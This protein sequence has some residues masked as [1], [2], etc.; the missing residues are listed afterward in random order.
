M[1]TMDRAPDTVTAEL[2]LAEA[3][4]VRRLAGALVADPS[5]A[6]DVAQE[7]LRRG[8]EHPPTSRAGLRGWLATVARNVVRSRFRADRRRAGRELAV[9]RPEGE[10][11]VD[12]VVAR[13]E[14]HRRVVEAVLALEEPYRS[15]ILHRYFDDLGPTAIAARTGTPVDT[16]RTHLHRALGRLRGRL[17]AS[18]GGD[19]AATRRALLALMGPAAGASAPADAS[20]D[21]RADASAGTPRGRASAP[22]STSRLVPWLAA[23]TVV[24]GGVTLLLRSQRDVP[25]AG[26][27]AS[28]TAAA[29]PADA[30]DTPAPAL[31]REAPPRL[32]A[33]GNAHRGSAGR[34]PSRTARLSGIVLDEAG[35]PASGVL[36]VGRPWRSTREE[37]QELHPLRAQRL[38][39][40][41]PP[42]PPPPPRFRTRSDATGAFSL[43]VEDTEAT[44]YLQVAAEPAAPAVG[45]TRFY[46]WAQA[47]EET[48]TLRVAAGA[49]LR[50]RIV[51]A[52]GHGLAATVS[53]ERREPAAAEPWR[54][55]GAAVAD[56]DGR[57]TLDAAPLGTLS[58]DVRAGD[59]LGVNGHL[60]E[61]RAGEE[62]LVRVGVAGGAAVEG[63]VTDG[64]GAPVRGADVLVYTKVDGTRNEWRNVAARTRADGTYRVEGLAACLLSTLLVDA[65][66]FAPISILRNTPLAAGTTERWD[67]R[68][69]RGATLRGRVLGEDG[70]VPEG[71]VVALRHPDLEPA[72]PTR[73]ARIDAEGRFSFEAV[74]L[75][76]AEWKVNAPG[77]DDPA[78]EAV[79]V[80]ADGRPSQPWRSLRLGTEGESQTLELRLRRGA[81]VAGTVV[82]GDGRPVEGARIEVVLP[83]TPGAEAGSGARPATSGPDGRFTLD[84]LPPGSGASLRALLP[85]ARTRTD[86]P[87][88]GGPGPHELVL[89]LVRTGS[90]HGRV[91]DER[92]E[93]LRRVHVGLDGGSGVYAD[94]AGRFRLS[95]VPIGP[96]EVHLLDGQSRPRGERI[97]V[98]L[99]PEGDAPAVE[100]RVPDATRLRGVVVTADGTPV[101]QAFVSAMQA[102]TFADMYATV[103]DAAGAFEFLGMT[104]GPYRLQF[105]G[106]T[107]AVTVRSGARDVRLVQR[108]TPAFRLRGTLVDPEGRPVPAAVVAVG[109]PNGQGLTWHT[110]PAGGGRFDLPVPSPD[111]RVTVEV[112]E[113][114][115]EAGRRLPVRPWHGEGLDVRA[116]LAIRLEAGRH[117]EGRV[118]DAAGRGVE[119]VDVRVVSQGSGAEPRSFM[120]STPTTRTDAEGRFVFE[121]LSD[122]A[123]V[124]S[125]ETGAGRVA[126]PNVTVAAGESRVAIE[127]PAPATVSGRVLDDRGRPLVGVEVSGETEER[128]PP[129]WRTSTDA[130]GRFRLEQLP[131]DAAKIRVWLPTPQ[132]RG[133]D[134]PWLA[135]PAVVTKPGAIDVVVRLERGVFVEGT[136]LDEED[137]PAA[138]RI[139]AY[140]EPPSELPQ[141]LFP[142]PVV[143]GTWPVDP[144]TGHFA[145]GP[146]RPGLVRLK[147]EGVPGTRTES[148]VVPV[149]APSRDVRIVLR[150]VPPVA[151][152]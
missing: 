44:G 90:I 96:H 135:D 49:R 98:T 106:G 20:T 86:V 104:P 2:L 99:P 107:D 27:A 48:V 112:F 148:E 77:W 127:L 55:T 28:S 152:R 133:L 17:E 8:L 59:R 121:G 29:T 89:T 25:G 13:A 26:D 33:G 9:A 95:E 108:A 32:A 47:G 130:E 71:A 22:L 81:A 60:V 88:P 143:A 39:A 19:R 147:G 23:V 126:V 7:T 93:G 113:A 122:G 79:P 69:F 76:T 58:L 72:P 150:P 109:F 103:T 102:G 40:L 38:E 35:A 137:R 30:P 56:D 24:A 138:G 105:D 92:G 124:L 5:F 123:V 97:A 36:V 61:H 85:G 41:R 50:G 14:E 84:A 120:V 100:L 51:D 139:V 101:P 11:P 116:P 75:G 118:L 145:A 53:I 37:G 78:A 146:V 151:P 74:A 62:V 83:P 43:D 136:L 18:H 134:W 141:D 70:S 115:D 111:V 12:D 87:I 46:A 6:D 119:A 129:R 80:R 52:E 67:V 117:L 94:E 132:G 142:G 144:A 42:R 31:D 128:H 91:V 4:W 21:A 10:G 64:T 15:T 114:A 57:F 149:P 110:H 66:G 34:A 54:W 16:V 68:L 140:A 45:S 3:P 125:V 65:E 82:W 131:A 63:T 1:G 73:L